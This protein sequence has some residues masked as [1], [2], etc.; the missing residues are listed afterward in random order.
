LANAFANHDVETMGEEMA[1]A[2]HWRSASGFAGTP[3][4]KNK[5]VS[6]IAK[7]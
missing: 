4:Q 2:K 5:V 1:L 6:K 3:I 7:T